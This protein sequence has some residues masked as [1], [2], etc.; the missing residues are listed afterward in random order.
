MDDFFG[1]RTVLIL[2]ETSVLV[3]GI[4]SNREEDIVVDLGGRATPVSVDGYYLTA[5]HLV[6]D[7]TPVMPLPPQKRNEQVGRFTFAED[8]AQ[9]LYGRVVKHFLPADLAIIKFNLLPQAYFNTLTSNYIR[10][11]AV[12]T[13]STIGYTM[14]GEAKAGNGPFR[15]AGIIQRTEPIAG[16]GSSQRIYTSIVA[17]G[18]MSGAPVADREGNLVGI[19]VG[20]NWSSITQRYRETTLEIVPVNQILEAIME[21]RLVLGIEND[22][23]QN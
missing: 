22:I 21:D 11:R 1:P 12:F 8:E 9:F 10:G 17:R 4:D 15:A 7:A 3:Q 18:G 16:T 14:S 23:D 5:Y 13:G 2:P 19:I 6:R 20:G